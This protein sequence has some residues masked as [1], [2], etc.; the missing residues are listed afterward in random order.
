[1]RYAAQIGVFCRCSGGV[2]G[3]PLPES[4]QGL[5]GLDTRQS[6][7]ILTSR[8]QARPAALLHKSPTLGQWL[9]LRMHGCGGS[10][11]LLPGGGGPG[12]VGSVLMADPPER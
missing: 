9:T 2:D 12:C 1:M 3:H 8:Y 5:G 7:Q 6:W 4:G 11:G 10:V